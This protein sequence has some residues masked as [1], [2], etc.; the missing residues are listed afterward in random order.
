MLSNQIQIASSIAPEM[1]SRIRAFLTE[2]LPTVPD[3]EYTE[4]AKAADAVNFVHITPYT[5]RV[6]GA[7]QKNGF[8]CKLSF[9]KDGRD[10]SATDLFFIQVFPAGLTLHKIP[11][12]PKKR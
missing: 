3:S 8:M 6:V 2:T 11:I 9:V 5:G 4:L 7:T 1:Q 10:Q 12:K